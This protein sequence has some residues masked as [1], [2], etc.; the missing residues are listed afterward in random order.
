MS[1]KHTP[2]PWAILGYDEIEG[3]RVIEICA[4]LI[5]SKSFV[6]IAYVN[7]DV[8]EGLTKATK[9]NAQLIA[10]APELL[11][12]LKEYIEAEHTRINH[13]TNDV[14]GYELRVY[15][16]TLTKARLAINKAEGK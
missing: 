9:A 10:A 12:A 1:N 6:N 16:S 2:T 7:G 8:D 14:P 11:E 5:G 4:G 3:L 15:T 13:C